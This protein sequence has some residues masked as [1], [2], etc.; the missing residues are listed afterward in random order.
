MSYEVS[1]QPHAS[2][3]W[4]VEA[5]DDDGGIE[6]AIFI[7]PRAEV[8]ARLYALGAYGHHV[9]ASVAAGWLVPWF[10]QEMR[11][12]RSSLKMISPT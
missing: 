7:G 6:Q 3:G 12:A 4:A 5:I 9:A 10:E 11:G 2:H 8:R 1:I